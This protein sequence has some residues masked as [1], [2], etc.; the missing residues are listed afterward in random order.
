M[1]GKKCSCIKIKKDQQAESS[2]RI[3]GKES[4]GRK[5]PTTRNWKNSHQATNAS[6][7]HHEQATNSFYC[8]Y[9]NSQSIK[10]KFQNLWI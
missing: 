7:G 2:R 4:S 10:K 9:T 1:A 6:P 8:Y 5:Q 3:E